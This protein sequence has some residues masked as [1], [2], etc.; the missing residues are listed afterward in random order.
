LEEWEAAL[1][2]GFSAKKNKD[3]SARLVVRVVKPVPQVEGI[4]AMRLV[5]C[6]VV[7]KVN[8]Y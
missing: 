4:V 2:I 6:L 1:S 5:S 7:E 3:R 8:R